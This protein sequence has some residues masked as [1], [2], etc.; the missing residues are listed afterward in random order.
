MYR[1]Y[2][3]GELYL[4][5]TYFPFCK[6]ECYIYNPTK[7]WW[8]YQPPGITPARIIP[9]YDVPAVYRAINLLL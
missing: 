1:V 7:N 3:N 8:S 2:K 4:E 9:A 5:R 6:G